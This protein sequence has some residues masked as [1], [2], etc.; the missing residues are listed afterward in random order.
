MP[1]HK[2][3]ADRLMHYWC[4]PAVS[5]ITSLIR[6]GIWSVCSLIQGGLQYLMMGS[7]V[8]EIAVFAFPWRKNTIRITE[9]Y[10]TNKPM[11]KLDDLKCN[12]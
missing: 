7:L 4:T 12:F 2:K 6:R 1:I 8:K 9:R 10:L 11:T 5:T 3:V